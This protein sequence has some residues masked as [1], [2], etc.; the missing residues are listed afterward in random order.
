MN[1]RRARQG[2]MPSGDLKKGLHPGPSLRGIPGD[3]QL[4]PP[5]L[6]GPGKGSDGCGLSDAN[7]HSIVEAVEH[8][9]LPIWAVQWHP[10][11]MT[12]PVTN[13]ENCVDSLPIFQYF[14]DQC[15]K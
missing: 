1:W 7:G 3:Q 12:G 11:R 14:M 9:S 6:K 13:P 2:R 10:E 15:R 8:V 5:G 4:P